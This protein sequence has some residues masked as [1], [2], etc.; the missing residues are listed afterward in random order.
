MSKIDDR[1][2]IKAASRSFY[3]YV[4]DV[5]KLTY[6]IFGAVIAL[7]TTKDPTLTAKILLWPPVFMVLM[8][9]IVHKVICQKFRGALSESEVDLLFEE[10][11]GNILPKEDS[12]EISDLKDAKKKLE[13]FHS[14][15]RGKW[16][17]G[18]FKLQDRAITLGLIM[19]LCGLLDLAFEGLLHCAIIG[20][21]NCLENVWQNVWG[22]LQSR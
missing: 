20:I 18:F 10:K 8:H 11:D 16:G 19:V 7:A 1:D 12:R 9:A 6:G 4:D 22:L 13:D 17:Y 3:K 21:M 14:F 2:T 5:W 15:C